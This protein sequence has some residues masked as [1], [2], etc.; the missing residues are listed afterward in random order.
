MAPIIGIDLGTTNSAVAYMKNGRPVIV[1]NLQ[2]SALTP[3]V[4]AFA[5]DGRR[6]VGQLAKTANVINLLDRN[7][8]DEP[9]I[10]GNEQPRPDAVAVVSSIKRQMGQ[11]HIVEANGRAFSPV[12]I[13]TIIL[14][15]LKSDA[16]VY[17]GESIDRAVITVPAYFND[18]QRRATKNA[19]AMAGLEVVRLVNEPTAAALAYGLDL[20]KAHTIL[21]WDLGGGTFDVSLLE[22]G[23][24][25]FEVKAVNGNTHLGGDDYDDRLAEMLA[26]H[27]R[28]EWH[29]DI[30]GEPVH[31]R[32]MLRLAEE[33]KIRLSTE[34]ETQVVLPRSLGR[35]SHCAVTV[36]R[37]AFEQATAD[38]TEKMAAP[39]RQVL[40]DAG[41]DPLDLDR[42]V[43]VGGMTRVPAVRRLVKQITGLEPYGHIDPDRVVALG[44]AVQAGVL[45]GEVRNVTLVDVTPLSLG[46]ETQGG[47]FARLIKRNTT[48]PAAAGRLFT[49][50]R[51]GQTEMDI[52]VL[53]GERELANENVTL[54]N[55]QLSGMTPQPR[56][57]VKVE[58]TFDI[59]AN[60][61]VQVSATDLQTETS[62]RIRIEAADRPSR[63]DADRIL[64]ESCKYVESDIRKRQ[65][66]EARIRAENLI[67][68][69][70]QLIEE[71]GQNPNE[72]LQQAIQ[73]VEEGVG[74]TQSA[75]ADGK[76][77]DIEESTKALGNLLKKLSLEIKTSAATV[78]LQGQAA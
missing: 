37:E 5:G 42:V 25:V 27:F 36:T 13:S 72:G 62:C 33:A 66:I 26:E 61:M 52:H 29:L 19:A 9:S 30:A 54:G 50:A 45:A 18:N 4:V 64:V 38:I 21:V 31:K 6:W 63:E 24:G 12:E 7:S 41:Y 32:L 77:K 1:P 78:G 73:S 2:G 76:P 28:A 55:F 15:K 35:G 34:T 44:A 71:T 48:I 75:L 69:A 74:K 53:Q 65:E 70:R 68:A 16:E 51:D 67:R 57:Q 46:I 23:D 59:D 47:L 10:E 40:T 43:L 11:D 49:N 20:E 60:G 17:L 39:A 58:V 3:S 14:E 22:L 8:S 56:G